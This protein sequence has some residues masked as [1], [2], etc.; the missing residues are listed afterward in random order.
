MPEKNDIKPAPTVVSPFTRRH[1]VK[2][3]AAKGYANARAVRL[4]R[5]HHGQ[6]ADLQSSLRGD[7]GGVDILDMS[8]VSNRVT[9]SIEWVGATA[10]SA[11]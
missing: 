10:L 3:V 8:T 11:R 1:R 4:V 5:N 6:C 9:Q 2:H 7:W